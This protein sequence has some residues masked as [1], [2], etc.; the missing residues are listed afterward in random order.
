MKKHVPNFITSLNLFSGCVAVLL[1]FKGNY[2]GA[3]IAI[4]LS[5]IFDFFDGFAARL[6]KAYSP[7]GKELD[8]LADIISFGMAPGAIVFS[9]LSGNTFSEWLPFVAFLIP[10]FSGL[11]LAKFNIDD[12]QTSSFI[13]LPVPANAIF[14]AGL[15]FSFSPF[16][17]SNVCLLLILIGLFCY[18]LISEI[19]MFSLKFKNAGWND[20]QLQY[21]FLIVCILFLIAFQ[22]NA[23]A[24]IIG[25]YILL[26]L[27]NSMFKKPNV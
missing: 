10:V 3:F 20:N 16:L 2:E 13:G 1:A 18:F 26:S 19:P 23:F 11:R 14:W 6:L 24:P 21:I 12:R 5:A 22:Q 15:V 27:V 4:L 9:L 17:L 25:W 8:S 7:M